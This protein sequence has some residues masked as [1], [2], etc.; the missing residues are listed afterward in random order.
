MINEY[1]SHIPLSYAE[2]AHL[3][4]R[5]SQQQVLR[6]RYTWLPISL[7]ELARTSAYLPV[8]I[9][10]QGQHWSMVVLLDDS[11]E[12]QANLHSAEEVKDQFQPMCLQAY[13]F[14]LMP[15]SAH[16]SGMQLC[17]AE[18]AL[19]DLQEKGALP[20]FGENRQFSTAVTDRFH[21]LHRMKIDAEIV[22]SAC[23]L[24]A[25]KGVLVLISDAEKL[26]TRIKDHSVPLYRID[27]D[28]IG[29]LSREDFADLQ[30]HH[31]MVL[32]IYQY[33]SLFHVSK[34][35]RYG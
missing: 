28:A 17:I 16:K 10:Q 8:V 5:F 27:I 15:Y 11:L 3:G 33:S 21:L 12:L 32:G 13:P 30:M 34:F 23:E 18:A 26:L 29:R 22:H 14:S 1:L 7:S 35:H 20:L 2:H 24:L 9:M 31:A 19:A 6:S 4:W 25:K